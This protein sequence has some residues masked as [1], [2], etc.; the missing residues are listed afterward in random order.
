MKIMFMS[1]IH[2]SMKYLNMAMDKFEEEK[3]DKIVLLGDLLEGSRNQPDYFYNP[4]GL[5][6]LLNQYKDKIIAVSG[7]CDNMMDQRLL[8]FDIRANYKEIDFGERRIFATHGHRYNKENMPELDEGDI[9]IHGHL[10]VPIAEMFEGVYYLNPGSVSLP[11]QNSKNSYGILDENKFVI[12]D[13]DGN[14]VKEIKIN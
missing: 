11:R 1:D 4:E 13:L 8:E 3:A 5:A 12:K 6:E 10:H 2:G 9:F 7:N 14:I